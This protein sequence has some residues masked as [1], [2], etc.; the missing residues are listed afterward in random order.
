QSPGVTL[1]TLDRNDPRERTLRVFAGLDK[2]MPDWLGIVFGKGK[3]LLPPLLGAQLTEDGINEQ[4]KRLA[5]QCTCMEDATVHSVSVPMRWDAALDK[6][7]PAFTPRLNYAASAR[8]EPTGRS[9]PAAY[10]LAPMLAFAC[11]ALAVTGLTIRRARRHRA[12][13]EDLPCGE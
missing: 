5:V 9:F 4:L 3:L 7:I 8:T 1:V 10:V 12:D 11:V 6:R 13:V 2:D